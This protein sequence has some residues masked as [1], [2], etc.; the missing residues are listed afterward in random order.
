M[1]GRI[2]RRRPHAAQRARHFVAGASAAAFLGF[3]GVMAVS[4]HTASAGTNANSTP[5]TTTRSVDPFDQ[6][7]GDTYT[8]PWGDGSGQ[9]SDGWGAQPP[10][11]GVGSGGGGDTSSHGS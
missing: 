1:S 10:S 8:D 11:G 2:P 3:G 7:S 4:S 9:S 5:A 6:W